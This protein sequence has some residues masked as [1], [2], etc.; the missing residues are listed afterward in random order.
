MAKSSASRTSAAKVQQHE[1]PQGQ[2]QWDELTRCILKHYKDLQIAPLNLPA[3]VT[4]KMEALE[5]K[6]CYALLQLALNRIIDKAIPACK[7]SKLLDRYSRAERVLRA[8]M[9]MLGVE[10]ND[11][12]YKGPQDYIKAK[13][14]YPLA[15]FGLYFRRPRKKPAPGPELRTL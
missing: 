1:Q 7:S 2:D 5:L 3:E 15:D 10:P 9:H 4:D 14:Q 11:P 12:I 8:A 6:E 13:L